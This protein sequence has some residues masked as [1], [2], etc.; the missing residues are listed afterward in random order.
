MP[1]R[2]STCDLRLSKQAASTTAPGPPVNHMYTQIQAAGIP[3]HQIYFINNY[4]AEFF[5]NIFH[6]FKAGIANA[7]PKLKKIFKFVKNRYLPN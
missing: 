7:I 4:A 3:L 6:S 1:E 5:G 2:G